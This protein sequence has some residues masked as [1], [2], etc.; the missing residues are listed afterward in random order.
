MSKITAL[1]DAESWTAV[2]TPDEFQ[3]I[4]NSWTRVKEEEGEAAEAGSADKAE[5]GVRV[6]VTENGVATTTEQPLPT[7]NGESYANGTEQ[8]AGSNRGSKAELTQE[9]QNEQIKGADASVADRENGQQEE[10]P[11]SVADQAKGGADRENGQ[12]G[13]SARVMEQPQAPLSRQGSMASSSAGL[14]RTPSEAELNSGET[15]NSEGPSR[16][17]AEQA[18]QSD[19]PLPPAAKRKPRPKVKLIEVR[20]E[21]YHAVQSALMLLKILTEYLDVAE[22]LPAMATEVVHRV[23]EILKLFNSRSCQLVLGAGAMQVGGC[24]MAVQEFEKV[25]GFR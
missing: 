18:P 22:Q 4:V 17:N 13:A 14:S 23:A 24:L 25:F 7:A 16:E 2:D 11:A 6:G 20:G 12:P 3:A 21:Q 19:A 1:L 8:L 15:T 5:Q 10:V 9:D